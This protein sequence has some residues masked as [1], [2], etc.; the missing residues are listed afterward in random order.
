MT[1]RTIIL[2]DQKK[3][4]KERSKQKLSTLRMLTSAIK[5][6]EI[7]KQHELSDEEV[8]EVIAR[9]AKQLKDAMKDFESGG[10]DDLLEKTKSELG[11]LEAYLPEQLSDE[12]LEKVVKATAEKVGASSSA[13][14]GKIM[15]AVMGQVK[16][17]AD[18]N[19]VRAI[20]QKLLSL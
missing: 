13:D 3:A 9:Q 12:E 18:G 20:V 17:K 19:R 15:G 5:N 2:E 16:G 6:V 10:R 14:M 4:M 7:E 8:L 1:L 11:V